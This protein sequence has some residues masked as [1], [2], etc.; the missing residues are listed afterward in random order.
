MTKLTKVLITAM[1]IFLGISAV[2]ANGFV[3]FSFKAGD[4][5]KADEVNANFQAL[6]EGKQNAITSN[7]CGGGQFV[8]GV[9]GDGTLACGIDQIGSAGSSGVSSL[10]GK[11]GSL[12]IEGGDGV[13]VETSDDGKVTI[14]AVAT[15]GGDFSPQA[16]IGIPSSGAGNVAG[17]A[18]KI[19]NNNNT[20]SSRA[21]EAVTKGQWGVYASGGRTGVYGTGTDSGVNGESSSSS[22]SRG[23]QGSSYASGAIGVLGQQSGGVGYGVKGIQSGSGYGVYGVSLS[24]SIG[25]GGESSTGIGVLGKITSSSAGNTS[26]AVSGINYGNTGIG[27]RGEHKGLGYGVYGTAPQVGVGGESANIG[28][29]GIGPVAMEAQGN[30]RQTLGSFGWAK[31]MVYIRD[32]ILTRCFNSQTTNPALVQG[33]GCGFKNYRFVNFG[34]Y[35]REQTIDFGFDVTNTFPMLTL[36]HYCDGDASSQNCAAHV[37]IE[38]PNTIKVFTSDLDDDWTAGGEEFFLILF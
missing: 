18:F 21:I 31:A 16:T 30:V 9:N 26:V 24:G 36:G 11:T 19:T 12:A 7:P 35:A 5:I 28:V 25:V 34:G 33:N 3:P 2:V 6:A 37:Q 1:L 17:A 38:A 23:V 14:S 8:T 29:R 13:T 22:S 27:V 4:P 32:G 15:T 10:N 20:T